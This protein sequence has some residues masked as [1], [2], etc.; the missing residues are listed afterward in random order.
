L[1]LSAEERLPRGV[2]LLRLFT[3]E[4]SAGPLRLYRR[5]GYQNPPFTRG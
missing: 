2:T 4:H 5:L 1:L 3:G